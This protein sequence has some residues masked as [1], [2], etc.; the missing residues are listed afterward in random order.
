MTVST[1]PPMTEPPVTME[2]DPPVT[3]ATDPPVTMATDPPIGSAPEF[4]VSQYV[5]GKVLVLVDS[6]FFCR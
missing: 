6:S 3:M 4:N 2:T 5:V 1:D